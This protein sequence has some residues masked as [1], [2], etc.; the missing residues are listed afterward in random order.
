M[1]G[2]YIG[3]TL[4]GSTLRLT[5]HIGDPL[6]LSLDTDPF[7]ER[8]SIFF[9]HHQPRTYASFN[10]DFRRHMG[11]GSKSSSQVTTTSRYINGKYGSVV[12]KTIRDNQ[13][14]AMKSNRNNSNSTANPHFIIIG[15]TCD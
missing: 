13:V 6:S 14:R 5:W 8:P 1:M 4:L 15:Y 11:N 9:E 3:A 12:V 7:F 2:I 10:T